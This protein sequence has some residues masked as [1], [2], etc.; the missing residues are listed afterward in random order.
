MAKQIYIDE[1]GNENL[2]SGTINYGS[3]LPMSPNDSSSMVADRI[4]A[5]ET[6]I[7]GIIE[8]GSNTNG[9]Y[10]KYADGTM[11]CYK[12]VS[13]GVAQSD[14]SAWGACYESDV[15]SLGSWAETFYATPIVHTTVSGAG[16]W[17][18]N[19]YDMSTTS[20]GKL[21]FV[22]PSVPSGGITIQLQVIGIGRWK[23]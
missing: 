5:C 10:V 8:S 1:N 16:A 7:S 19:T 6:A 13:S 21:R 12:S 15:K 17:I 9:N 23:A 20:S 18:E 14:W 4:E 11:I 3:L 2:V 22:R